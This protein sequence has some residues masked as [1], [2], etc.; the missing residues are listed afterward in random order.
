VNENLSL[1][2]FID[3]DF[4]VINR[5]L[6]DIYQLELPEEEE[7]P[8]TA[9]ETDSKLI[10]NDKKRR[11]QSIFRKVNL[12]AASPRGGLLTQAG[13][14]MMTTNGEFTNPF[15]RGA[16]VAK[17]LYGLNL[18]LP[19]NLEIEALTSP[20]ETFTIKASMNEHRKNPQCASCHSKMDP[21]GLAMENFDVL[22]RYRDS[23][24]KHVVTK[25]PYEEKRDG[26]VVQKERVTHKFVDT[27]A[28]ESDAVHRDGRTIAGMIGL[29]N[30]L[31]Q[32][33]EKIAKNLL[34][35]LSEYSLGREMNYGDAER[36][37]SLLDASRKNDYK[38]RDL[39]LSIIADDTFTTR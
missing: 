29:K 31:L 35:K 21:F 33:K 39:I 25:V 5:P 9:K 15:Y 28:V 27:T 34:T 20:N 19:A 3:S 16:W 17:C 13:V 10:L 32:D 36:I 11:Q 18:E 37:Q 12:D 8:R 30:L 4:V 2:N 23:Y 7:L 1:L 38:L 6:N 14:L 24:Q 26:K 22:G